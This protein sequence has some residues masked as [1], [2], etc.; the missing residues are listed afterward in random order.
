MSASKTTGDD[1]LPGDGSRDDL[2]KAMIRVD[3][4]GEYGAKRIY[5]GQLAVL[6]DSPSARVIAH[7]ADQEQRHLD[8]F[9]DLLVE[10][11]VRPTLLSPVWHVAGYALGVGSALL[12]EKAA[13]ACTEAVESVIDEHYA[14]Q[15]DKLGDDEAELR[16]TVEQFRA[17]EQEHHDTALEHGAAEAPAHDLLTGAVKT[18]TRLAIWLST[19]V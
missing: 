18:G 13:M 7:M 6:G 5:D 15:A 2:V 19:R 10:R 14:D 16:S 12:G 4:A 17:E 9:D 3:H 11:R 8:H 1:L